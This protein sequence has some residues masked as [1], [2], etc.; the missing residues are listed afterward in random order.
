MP[1]ADSSTPFTSHAI[2]LK[3]TFFVGVGVLGE[4]YFE[5]VN[6]K[7]FPFLVFLASSFASWKLFLPLFGGIFDGILTPT[8]GLFSSRK[9]NI[10]YEKGKMKNEKWKMKK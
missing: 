4:R 1:A 8:P 3:L 2:P 5:V 9:W 10:K 6:P 7:E